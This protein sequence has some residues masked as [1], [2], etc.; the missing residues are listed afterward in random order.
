LLTCFAGWWYFEERVTAR[1]EAIREQR[2]FAAAV[3]AQTPRTV[4]LFRVESHLLAFHLGRPL[5]TLVEWGELNDL[6]AQPGTH[7]VV[8]QEGFVPECQQ[9][10]HSRR[11][12][13]VARSADFAPVRPVR[14][15][16]LLRAGPEHQ[17]ATEIAGKSASAW[18][19]QLT[20][21]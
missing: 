16:V 5:H 20:R 2:G 11:L 19:T 3:R 21:D 4:L 14:P 1:E 9:N 13:V 7:Y 17:A 18:P 15:L 6:L 8:T 12:E 10:V